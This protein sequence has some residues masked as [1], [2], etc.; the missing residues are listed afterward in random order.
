VNQHEELNQPQ[1]PH[2]ELTQ[3][4][5]SFAELER[6]WIQALRPVSPPDGFAER[7]L[8]R[9]QPATPAQANVIGMTARP[10]HSITWKTWTSG[11]IA[12]ALLAG[13]FIA[14][15]IHARQQR[16]EA[17]RAEQQ[18]DV[19]L[20]I[21]SETLAQTRQQLQQAGIELGN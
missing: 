1:E 16:E 20:R 2:R 3:P 15:Q 19:A 12:A 10:R 17:K 8:A 4:E 11:A 21:T 6:H 9:V 7:I 18:F 14:G 13:L 5:E